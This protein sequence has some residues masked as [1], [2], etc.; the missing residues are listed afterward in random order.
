MP[1]VEQPDGSWYFSFSEFA[2]GT[3][4]STQ[5]PGVTFSSPFLNGTTNG[6]PFIAGDGANPFAPCLSGAVTYRDPI[7]A[8]F[9]SPVR[10]LSFIYGYID[11][12]RSVTINLYFS[13]TKPL[14]SPDLSLTQPGRGMVA[15]NSSEFTSAGIWKLYIL[16]TAGES[17]GWEMD[18]L[19]FSRASD[20]CLYVNVAKP[21]DPPV[22][23]PVCPDPANNNNQETVGHLN[24][25]YLDAEAEEPP[26]FTSL[27][28]TG[29]APA[30]KVFMINVSKNP[31]EPDWRH[32]CPHAPGYEPPA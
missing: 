26:G 32:V 7:L 6:L 24:M 16:N 25:T 12:E 31:E 8:E 2:Q 22:W 20:P 14:D 17:A 21:P 29:I 23:R 1:L 15:F 3:R 19:R 28:Y 18:E 9:H 10:N 4:I 27:H 11:D 5:Y 13:K 30:D